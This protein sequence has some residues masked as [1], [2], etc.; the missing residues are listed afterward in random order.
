MLYEDPRERLNGE[1]VLNFIE[2]QFEL[3]DDE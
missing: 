3:S 2:E 1:G